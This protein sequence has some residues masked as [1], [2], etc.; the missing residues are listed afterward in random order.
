MA[1][2]PPARST[3]NTRRYPLRRAA[4]CP[5]LCRPLGGAAQG[6]AAGVW[7][8]GVQRPTAL[9]TR[10]GERMDL[11]SGLAAQEKA[12]VDGPIRLDRLLAVRMAQEVADGRRR[13]RQE[14]KRRG[15][16]GGWARRRPLYPGRRWA[17]LVGCAAGVW[18]RR[19]AARRVCGTWRSDQPQPNAAA[20][21]SPPL[22]RN[23]GHRSLIDMGNPPGYP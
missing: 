10:V 2:P 17:W 9:F 15:R 16:R 1:G 6:P 21:R 14:A 23:G 4:S 18:L 7:R 13:V 11:G 19:L 5:G 22:G 12:A 8:A 3:C 20:Y